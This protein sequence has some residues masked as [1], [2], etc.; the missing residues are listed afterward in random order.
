MMGSQGLRFGSGVA[1]T[2]NL[3]VTQTLHQ[4]Q[5]RR[6]RRDRECCQDEYDF[7]SGREVGITTRTIEGR[8]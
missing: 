6:D 2:E 3:S 7:F 8:V 5:G 1:A 4:N